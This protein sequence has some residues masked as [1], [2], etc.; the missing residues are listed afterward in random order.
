MQVAGFLNGFPTRSF[1][2][3]DLTLRRRTFSAKLPAHSAHAQT[4]CRGW[5]G[6]FACVMSGS[7]TQVRR[8]ARRSKA[9]ENG[10]NGEEKWLPFLAA[11]VFGL[12]ALGPTL[13]LGS[14]ATWWAFAVAATVGGLL[15]FSVAVP[16]MITAAMI[17]GI[18]IPILA[19]NFLVAGSL[20]ATLVATLVTA[21][22]A[23]LLVWISLGNPLPWSLD[24]PALP[25]ATKK[26]DQGDLGESLSKEDPFSDWDRRFA[27][28]PVSPVQDRDR[29]PKKRDVDTSAKTETAP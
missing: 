14:I 1:P 26:G 3:P 9:P 4:G 10:A 22:C 16:M 15:Y 12:L 17:G 5:V 19:A 11:G 2:R 27:E 8:A 20:V 23:G 7:R 13:L 21:G 28:T 18:V 24:S 6:G 29:L 25:F